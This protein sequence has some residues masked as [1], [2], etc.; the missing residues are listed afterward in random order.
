MKCAA[1]GAQN[2]RSG[3]TEVKPL[4]LFDMGVVADVVFAVAMVAVA[5]GAVA[6]FQ[7]WVRDIRSSAYGAAVGIG[8]L[9]GGGGRLVGTGRGERD[10]FCFGGLC[11]SAEKAAQVCPPGHGD[12]V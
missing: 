8:L 10:G 3:L 7:L 1:T 12:H 4:L 2:K 5:A 11:L 6:K 9:D